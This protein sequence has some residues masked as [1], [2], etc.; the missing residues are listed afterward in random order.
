[1]ISPLHAPRG[2]RKNPSL[3]SGV[4]QVSTSGHDLVMSRRRSTEVRI[5]DLKAN[6]S[7][8][9]RAAQRGARITVLDRDTPIAELG[10][11]A[12]QEEKK[13]DALITRKA[14]LSFQ[15][16]QLPD[17]IDLGVD[18]VSLLLADRRRR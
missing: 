4:D 15:D 1:V 9:L 11:V 14:T 18:L 12:G 8:H 6:L 17:R 3:G 13:S 7:K 16:I 2:F 10:P 5:A